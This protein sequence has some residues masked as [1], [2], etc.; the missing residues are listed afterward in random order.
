MTRHKKDTEPA[1]G[2]MHQPALLL[3]LRVQKVHEQGGAQRARA[4]C[5]HADVLPGV[6]HREFA[7]EGEDG[8]LAGRVYIMCM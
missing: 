7:G 3:L 6:D 4:Q 1:H 8:A 2:D 5:I